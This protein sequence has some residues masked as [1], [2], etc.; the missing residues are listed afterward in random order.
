MRRGGQR[1]G[2]A[3]QDRRVPAQFVVAML[4]LGAGDS[5]ELIK[6]LKAKKPGLRIVVYSALDENIFAE[7][8]MRTGASGYVMKQAPSEKLASAIRDIANGSIYVSREVA[9]TA[10]PRSLQ[11]LR[12]NKRDRHRCAYH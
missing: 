2:C 1:I 4:R 9:L 6:E 3:K 8:A 10:F 7:R 11:H 5:L 12:K